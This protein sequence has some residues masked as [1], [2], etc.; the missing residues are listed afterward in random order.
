MKLLYTLS[1]IV[2]GGAFLII[3]STVVLSK[4]FVE[5]TLEE[6]SGAQQLQLAQQTMNRLD[7]LLYQRYLDIQVLSENETFEDLLIESTEEKQEKT[8]RHLQELSILTGPWDLLSIVDS[9][10]VVVASTIASEEGTDIQTYNESA[11][12]YDQARDGGVYHSDFIVS[13]RTQR[14]TIIF[15]APIRDEDQEGQPLQGIVIGHMSW[16]V[17]QEIFDSL[18]EH[19]VLMDS[20]GVVIMQ[21]SSYEAPTLIGKN[22]SDQPS[23][24]AVLAGESA[25]VL[26]VGVDDFLPQDSLLSYAPQQGYL[27]YEGSGW[28]LGVETPTGVAFRTAQTTSRNL[29]LLLGGLILVA[30]V[31]LLVVLYRKL[32]IPI[33]SLTAT[34][35]AIARGK[36]SQRVAFSADNELGVLA[37]T[38]N[39]MADS[40]IHA[41]ERA[42]RKEQDLAKNVTELEKAKK[43]TLNLLEDLNT[44]KAELARAKAK[45]EAILAGIG[46]G[47]FVLDE[48]KKIALFNKAAS[49]IT[50]WSSEEALGKPYR[51][52]LKFALEN[53]DKVNDGFIDKAFQ[54]N[55][56]G[57]ANHTVV[58]RKDGERVPVADSAAPLFN[59]QGKVGGVVVVFRDVTK[60]RELERMKEDFM[61]IAAHDLRTPITAVKGFVQMIRKGDLGKPP[62]GEIGEAL[63]DIEDATDRTIALVNDFL[64][65]ARI[66]KGKFTIAP[67][68]L[69][70]NDTLQDLH[71]QLSITVGDRPIELRLDV[72]K[73]LPLVLADREKI[74]QAVTNL[75]DNALKFT[76]Q[77]SVTIRA[78]QKN[79]QLVEVQIE[80][81]GKG[82]AADDLP[83]IFQRYFRGQQG[84]VASGRGGNLG[85]GLNTVRTIIEKHGGTIWVKSERDKGTTVYFTLPIAK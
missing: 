21:N 1:L 65:V 26:S 62:K 24:Q 59:V 11:I 20:H 16:P 12:A 25:S 38:F 54:G 61:N 47:V 78:S 7:R 79:K 67:A 84:E 46:D 3:V 8:L 36:T 2:L 17:M 81:T 69:D 37:S 60:E 80:D 27:S 5:D 39:T 6:S 51:E 35:E 82:I 50:G 23:V 73:Q 58:I 44:E 10:G 75:V 14:P 70:I 19:A 33:S 41:R 31:L 28:G 55:V 68:P 45:D 56:V 13:K 76:E 71:R 52:I 42:E 74:A 43:A 57:M 66:Q 63:A 40:L 18:D 34:A 83:K 29:S 4:Q 64:T 32:L 15:A 48:E 53:R 85:L 22:M 9:E 77:G 49:E 72:P 30:F